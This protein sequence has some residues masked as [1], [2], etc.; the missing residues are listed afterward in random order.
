MSRRNKTTLVYCDLE[1]F[2]LKKYDAKK[3]DVVT[4]FETFSLSGSVGLSPKTHYV[5]AVG[6]TAVDPAVLENM[7]AM[8][9]DPEADL[10]TDIVARNI[11]PIKKVERRMKALQRA[12]NAL[13]WIELIFPR[14]IANE[15]IGDAREIMAR[16]A[17]DSSCSNPSL[18][19]GVKALTTVFWV[20]VNSIRLIRSSWLGKR[21]E[22]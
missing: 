20:V 8:I 17:A 4:K 18:K 2:K 15:E 19:M 16:I 6:T 3:L 11:L 7:R 5:G 22:D 13:D 10:H 14:R 21:A 1:G 9:E 12:A